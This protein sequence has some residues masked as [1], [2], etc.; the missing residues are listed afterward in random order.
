MRPVLYESTETVFTH[1]GIGVLHDCITCTVIEERNGLYELEMQYPITGIHYGE[2]KELSII[3]AVP[4]PKK[5][6]QLFQVYL[7]SKPLNG[8]ITVK[9]EHI[10]YRLSHI[11]LSP[12]A[13]ET[14][15]EAM[16][17]LS[18]NAVEDCLFEFYSDVTVQ[19]AFSV[20]EPESIRSALGGREGS[21]LDT[22][23]GEY[24][25]DNFRVSLLQ[26][27]GRDRGVVLRYGKNITDIK[28]ERN[29]QN[30]ITGIYPYWYDGTTLVQLPE[31]VLHVDASMNFPYQRTVPVN[32]YNESSAADVTEETKEAPT[33]EELRN[34][35]ESYI[36]SHSLGVPKVSITVSF[37][38]LSKSKNYKG[39]AFLEE[40]YLCDTVTVEFEKLGISEKAKVIKIVYNVL[41]ER[42]DSVE[43]GE[44]TVKISS[45]IAEQDEKIK[46]ANKAREKALQQLSDK[47]AASSGLFITTQT[48]PSG[49]MIYY[50][51]DKST[52]EK[53]EIVWKL[54]AEAFGISTDGGL[55]YPY[56]FDVSGQAVLD[57]IYTVGLDAS[58]ITT[59]QFKVGEGYINADGSFSLASIK[60]INDN[61]DVLV[62]KALWI[63]YGLEILAGNESNLPYIDFRKDENA[64]G[65]RENLDYSARIENSA[66]SQISFW[67]LHNEEDTNP[68][69][70]T[71]YAGSFVNNS[72]RRLKRDIAYLQEADAEAVLM[73]LKPVCYRFLKDETLH[74]GFIYDEVKAVL[75]ESDWGLVQTTTAGTEQYGAVSTMELIADIVMV[76]QK[77]SREIKE[78][79]GE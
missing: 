29:I 6:E 17:E 9:A 22:Y 76:L 75:G 44:F 43:L 77:M 56:G 32:F 51:H 57:R 71:L 45:T 19:K 68:E 60:S 78:L 13:A 55:T 37:L 14:A 5:K 27:R 67:G 11:P 31:R 30:T 15:Q 50:M 25:W 21:V 49:A 66:D 1:N 47:L 52:L 46:Q 8:V 65:D 28:Q 3:K 34:Q 42:Y 63:A 70:C 48:Q 20:P 26:A 33:V 24:E 12:F 73:A 39:I 10:S 79:K 38:P 40:V 2:I 74:H 72:D 69:P 7:I 36:E 61:Q 58:H 16:A 53:S 4:A 59:G 35:A 41:K 64:P 23:G 62:N 18:T 54:T